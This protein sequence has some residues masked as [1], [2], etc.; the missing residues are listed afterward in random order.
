[1]IGS[2]KCCN[3]IAAISCASK[4]TRDKH[5]NIREI[6]NLPQLFCAMRPPNDPPSVVL[7]DDG[8]PQE[9]QIWLA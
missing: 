8:E 4:R 9:A 6:P 5:M 2:W 1:M 3:L 7:G